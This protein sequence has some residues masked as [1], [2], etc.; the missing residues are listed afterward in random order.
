MS[1]SSNAK[2]ELCRAEIG[3]RCCANAEAYGVLLYCNTFS[4]HGI[5]IVTEHGDFA[6]RLPKLFQKAFGVTFDDAPSAP[7]DGGKF[8]LRIRDR[9]KLAR[10]F[11]AYGMREGGEVTLHLNRGVLEKP[12]CELSFIRGAFLAG[13]SVTDPEKR[14]Y[15]ELE[16]THMKVCAETFSLLLDLGFSPRDMQRGGDALIYFNQSDQVEDFLTAIGA[17]LSAM[18]LM[19]AKVEKEMRNAI[20]RRVNCDDANATKTVD[21]AQQ[22]LAAIR[23]LRES[24]V[25]ESLPEQIKQTALL[26]EQDDTAPLAEIA[27]MLGVSKSAINHRMRKIMELANR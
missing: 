4:Q 8:V 11:D 20:N 23:K 18:G 14:Y 2:S 16:T 9:E 22:Q 17:P 7:S 24:G 13:G 12:C 3:K 6:L 21:A 26:R 15:L 19:E 25:F 1:F 5:K 27:A 10:I